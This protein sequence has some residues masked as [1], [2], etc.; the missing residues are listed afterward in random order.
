MTTEQKIKR[1]KFKFGII[2]FT[3]TFCILLALCTAQILFKYKEDI[4]TK[5]LD[6]FVFIKITLLFL[7]SSVTLSLPPGI[8]VGTTLY[9]RQICRQAQIIKIRTSIIFSVSIAIISFAW[10]AFIAPINN[11]HMMSLLF[12]IREKFPDKPLMRSDL[13]LFSGSSMTSNYYQLD[14]VIDSLKRITSKQNDNNLFLINQYNSKQIL[15]FQIERVSMISFPIFVFILFY[16]GMFLGILNRKNKL[17]L[18]ISGF[19]FVII[20]GIYFLS[21]YLKSLV[22]ESTLTPFLWQFIFLSAITVLTIIAYI[23][24][25]RLEKTHKNYCW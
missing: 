20:P 4:F 16:L 12:D 21:V 3:V 23:V 18:L 5:N 8:L 19:Y 9:Y 10:I 24:T 7:L 22:K 25:S 2:G 15:K 13:S 1:Q 17:I 6:T 14:H 11:L